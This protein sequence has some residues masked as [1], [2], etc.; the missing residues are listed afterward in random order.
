MVRMRKIMCLKKYVLNAMLGLFIKF[1]V[2]LHI[3][4]KL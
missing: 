2:Y 1:K 4:V 3:K